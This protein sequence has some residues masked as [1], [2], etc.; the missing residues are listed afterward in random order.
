MKVSSTKLHCQLVI[1]VAAIDKV[2]RTLGNLNVVL[3]RRM[4]FGVGSAVAIVKS[5]KSNSSWTQKNLM[6]AA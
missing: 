3:P 5:A 6:P 4:V 1:D 2:N